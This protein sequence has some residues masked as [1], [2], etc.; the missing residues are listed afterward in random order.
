MRAF[1]IL[2]NLIMFVL[3]AGVALI[4]A[5]WAFGAVQAASL[6]DVMT[7]FFSTEYGRGLLHSGLAALAA[8]VP[9]VGVGLKK[10]IFYGKV[11]IQA[12]DY[13]EREPRVDNKLIYSQAKDRFSGGVTEELRRVLAGEIKKIP[14]LSG[15]ITPPPDI[16]AET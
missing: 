13:M 15:V 7:G 1:N 2:H 3:M 11:V 8:A 16:Y 12:V 5:G 10:I 4:V 6:G 9:V 14:G